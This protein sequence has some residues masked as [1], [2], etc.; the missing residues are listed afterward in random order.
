MSRIGKHPVV[1]PG[2]V[3]V[4]VEGQTVSAKGKLGA[5]AVTLPRG[6]PRTTANLSRPGGGP[7]RLQIRRKPQGTQLRFFFDPARHK[8]RLTV[9]NDRVILDLHRR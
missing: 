2:G 4:A 3:T 9:E 1:V 8:G 5:L 7:V 6:R